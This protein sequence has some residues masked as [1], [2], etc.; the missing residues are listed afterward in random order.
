MT[1]ESG[2][3]EE[4]TRLIEIPNFI[5]T[6]RDRTVLVIYYVGRVLLLM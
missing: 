3:M 4:N 5:P 1:G 6:S 2:E